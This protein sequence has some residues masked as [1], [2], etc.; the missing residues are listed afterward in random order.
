MMI[1]SRISLSAWALASLAV[2]LPHVSAQCNPL[3]SEPFFYFPS[4]V[5]PISDLLV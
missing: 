2:I 4:M 1:I 5:I 3:T